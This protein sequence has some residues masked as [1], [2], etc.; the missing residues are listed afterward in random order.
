VGLLNREIFKPLNNKIMKKIL[1]LMKKSLLS[2]MVITCTFVLV[3]CDKDD[4]SNNS[5]GI[6]LDVNVEGKDLTLEFCLNLVRN[7]RHCENGASD[8]PIWLDCAHPNPKGAILNR[9]E[10]GFKV[11][12]NNFIA[13][14]SYY[15]Y[16]SFFFCWYPGEYMEVYF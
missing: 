2:V 3:T 11:Y 4:D 8:P 6:D 15:R 13:Q 5:D 12:D 10:T 16:R 14:H 7:H 9:I 1:T